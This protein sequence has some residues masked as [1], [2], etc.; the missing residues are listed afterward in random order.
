MNDCV[1]WT[2]LNC[3]AFSLSAS[4]NELKVLTLFHHK[5]LRHVSGDRRNAP[6][7]ELHS[8]TGTFDAFQQ[9]PLHSVRFW[10]RPSH[11]PK[12]DPLHHF[13]DSH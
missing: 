5:S 3:D 8:F 1:I 12:N 6:I 10:H 13:V 2:S 7:D 4:Q 9:L 11:I